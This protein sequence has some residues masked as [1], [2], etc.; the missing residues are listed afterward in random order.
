[1]HC[2]SGN[3][4]SCTCSCY[5]C[6]FMLP[7]RDKWTHLWSFYLYWLSIL[8]LSGCQK[9]WWRWRLWSKWSYT[10]FQKLLNWK[11]RWVSPISTENCTSIS[12]LE[13][14]HMPWVF[15]GNWSMVKGGKY[16]QGL[17]GSVGNL[18]WAALWCHLLC[19]CECCGTF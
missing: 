2:R 13:M 17:A 11:Y 10:H 1:M 14:C 5:F 19:I 6:C 15:C 16:L 7:K 3:V 18:I 4:I 8:P 9:L 12:F